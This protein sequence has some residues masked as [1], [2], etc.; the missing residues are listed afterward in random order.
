MSEACP[1]RVRERVRSAADALVA[2]EAVTDAQV[3]D[4]CAGRRDEW[5]LVLLVDGA[6][7]PGV[8]SE[9]GARRL[10]LNDFPARGEFKRAVVTA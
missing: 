9:L 4:P 6:L 2:F 7:P 3:L 8:L 5:T 1:R 10:E